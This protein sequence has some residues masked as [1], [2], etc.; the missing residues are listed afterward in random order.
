MDNQDFDRWMQQGLERY[1]FI[2]APVLAQMETVF[3]RVDRLSEGP[4]WWQKYWKG[5]MFGGL[6]IGGMIAL[7]TYFTQDTQNP[8]AYIPTDTLSIPFVS[9]S[10]STQAL[11]SLQFGREVEKYKPVS[12]EPAFEVKELRPVQAYA[13]GERLSP[14]L[15]MPE[16][17][18]MEVPTLSLRALK[19]ISFEPETLPLT[20]SVQVAA[21]NFS[22]Q[23]SRIW[24]RRMRYG[25][26]PYRNATHSRIRNTKV[27]SKA[28]ERPNMRQSPVRSMPSARGGGSRRR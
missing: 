19:P 12:S 5:G 6:A 28:Y 9:P 16:V 2:E 13:F 24:L 15:A 7:S 22:A 26:G 23:P 18:R 21:P 1:Q 27:N 14:T 3:D 17:P 20:Q 11:E 10:L 25:S 4:N 8:N